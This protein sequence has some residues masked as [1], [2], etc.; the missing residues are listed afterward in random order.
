MNEMDKQN[1]F[2]NYR[3]VSSDHI[4]NIDVYM[5]QLLTFFD[6]SYGFFRRN[7]KDNI[8]TKA[9]INNYVKA[10]IM[11]KPFKKKYT[12]KEVKKLIMIFH[13]KQILAINDIQKLFDL[14]EESNLSPEE[15]YEKFL[16]TE[17]KV[18]EELA[19]CHSATAA[20]DTESEVLINT[21][22]SLT[23]EACAKKRLA[24]KLLDKINLSNSL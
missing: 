17:Q 9:M 1:E 18:Y 10:G 7:P 11:A 23:T 12:K 24:E 13:L 20:E 4:P 5:D 2:L 14:V 8:L 19:R 6:Q 16:N 3:G 22:V 15:F 21:I